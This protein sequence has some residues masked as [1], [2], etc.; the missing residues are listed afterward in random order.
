[1]E[2]VPRGSSAGMTTLQ[3]LGSHLVLTHAGMGSAYLVRGEKARRLTEP[4]NMLNAYLKGNGSVVSNGRRL[5]FSDGMFMQGRFD[6]VEAT[7]AGPGGL[8]FWS[9][10]LLLTP[11]PGDTFVLVTPKVMRGRHGARLSK[12]RLGALAIEPGRTLEGHEAFDRGV[13]LVEF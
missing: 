1:M 7:K 13:V 12:R 8:R 10:Q 5:M 2:V 3:T 4:H 11:K 9:D 6:H